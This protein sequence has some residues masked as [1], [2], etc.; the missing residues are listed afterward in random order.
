MHQRLIASSASR[1]FW[2]TT[3]IGRPSGPRP[4]AGAAHRA[5]SL[6]SYLFGHA[7]WLGKMTASRSLPSHTRFTRSA[8]LPSARRRSATA[9][10]T[11][12]DTA[13]VSDWYE[14]RTLRR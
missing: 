11:A 12:G 10:R 3:G 2:A 14:R 5:S 13:S 8:A 6:F 4:Q 1:S 7:S 9:R